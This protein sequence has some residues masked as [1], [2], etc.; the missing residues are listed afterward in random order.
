MIEHTNLAASTDIEAGIAILNWAS[1]VI[2]MK[3]TDTRVIWI[4]E[5]KK[6][7]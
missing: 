5:T 7:A 6:T 3:I 1:S 2:V 4:I